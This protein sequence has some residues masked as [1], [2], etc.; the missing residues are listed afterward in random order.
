M[1]ACSHLT[2]FRDRKLGYMYGTVWEGLLDVVREPDVPRPT[3][4]TVAI[5]PIV[6][7]GTEALSTVIVAGFDDG[8]LRFYREASEAV[9]MHLCVRTYTA[10]ML[11][12][13]THML[14]IRI[15]VHMYRL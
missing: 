5:L 7:D 13:C 12:L 6:F 3:A 9:C 11:Y 4:T 15:Y 2:E 10:H 14:Y 8:I 1:I